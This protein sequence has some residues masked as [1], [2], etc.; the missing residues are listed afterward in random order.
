MKLSK[1][2]TGKL[3]VNGSCI[4]SANISAIN[5]FKGTGG[6]LA[7]IDNDVKR[8]V[9][10]VR[11]MKKRHDV[12]SGAST[13]DASTQDAS[14]Q[15]A[16]TQDAST[17]DASTQDASTS[18]ASTA[19]TLT[20][21]PSQYDLDESYN[22]PIVVDTT[23]QS[24]YSSAKVEGGDRTS[25]VAGHRIHVFD[26][27][28]SGAKLMVS[29]SGVV[30]VLV[31]AGGGSGG[32]NGGGWVGGGGGGGGGVVVVQSLPV[33]ENEEYD[34]EVGRGGDSVW[35][36]RGLNGGDSRFDVFRAIGGGGG[37][38]RSH[39]NMNTGSS[40]GSGGGGNQWS[41]GGGG[42]AEVPDDRPVGGTWYG[43]PGNS[44][45]SNFADNSTGSQGGGGG[46]GAGSSP[47]PE[48]PFDGGEGRNFSSL[49]GEDVG[50]DGYFAGGG[51]GRGGSGHDDNIK[52]GKGGGGHL[53]GQQGQG[54]TD[55]TGGGGG[56]SRNATSGRGGSGVVIVRYKL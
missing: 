10:L 43:N 23:K 56:G 41:G 21:N 32:S 3:C 29:K 37:G 11:E 24:S 44:G 9:E 22:P 8:I 54:G 35:K 48:S 14:T 46:G 28:G 45:N 53:E 39:G 31:V 50:D 26:T 36:Q 4:E 5:T 12:A 34:I 30:D 7:S 52:G 6:R 40:G 17:Q 13:Q 18:D 1:I 25:V 55:A 16:S 27:P 2:S 15:D 47:G 20:V 33:D 38:N 42:D 51:S 49:F 19:N